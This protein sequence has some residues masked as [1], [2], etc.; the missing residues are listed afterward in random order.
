MFSNRPIVSTYGTSF[1]VTS[2]YNSWGT[3]VP[4]VSGVGYSGLGSVGYGTTVTAPKRR[5][6][7]VRRF[8]WGRGNITHQLKLM[9]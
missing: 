6:G 4:S 9:S 7:F 3:S 8:A 5:F 2:G 1:P